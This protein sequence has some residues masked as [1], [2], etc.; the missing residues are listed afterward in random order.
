MNVHIRAWR[1]AN[2]E[3]VKAQ[4][5]RRRAAKLNRIPKWFGELD[6]FVFEEASSLLDLRRAAT[7]VD[8]N[9]DHMV[10]MQGKL[11]SGLHVWNNAQVIP[12]SLNKGKGNRL[13]YTEPGE[14]IA[15]L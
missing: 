4:S 14:W 8:W 1:Q 15:A 2:P 7:G 5:K 3:M 6:R 13:I 11:V 12:A 10:P 9:L